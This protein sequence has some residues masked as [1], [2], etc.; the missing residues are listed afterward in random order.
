MVFRPTYKNKNR[1]INMHYRS[2]KA[3][4][5]L[6][7][8][9]TGYC[10]SPASLA[11]I[12]NDEKEL[13][14]IADLT[15]REFLDAFVRAPSLR[16]QKLRESPA[17]VLVF[18]AQDIKKMG[19]N[20]LSDLLWTVAGVQVQIRNNNRY[21]LW[22]RG[23]QTEFN[24]KTTLLID[25][26]PI[27]DFFGGFQLDEA[28]PLDNVKRIEIIRGPGSALY[29]SN[30]FS[31]SIHVYT[32]QPG[33]AK[34][35]HEAKISLGSQQT[36]TAYVR[37]S[38]KV[39]KGMSWQ[40]QAKYFDTQGHVPLYDRAG[41]DNNTG[42]TPQQLSYLQLQAQSADKDLKFSA[43]LNNFDNLRITKGVQRPS[44]REWKDHRFSL[45]YDYDVSKDID[46][47]WHLYYTRSKRFEQETKFNVEADG[48]LGAQTR[49]DR[50]TDDI[51]LWGFQQNTTWA[52]NRQ[53]VVVMG[54]DI[55]RESMRDS[56]FTTHKPGVAVRYRTLVSKP[57][58][59]HISLD[60]YA[61]FSQYSQSF[62]KS[63]T[64]FTA[65]AR[66]DI[67]DEFDDQFSYHLG[68]THQFNGDWSGK[69]L[70]GTAFRAS[71]LLEFTRAADGIVPPVERMKTIEAQI[72]Y[73]VASRSHSVS[74]YHNGYRD[75]LRRIGKESFGSSGGQTMYGVE[76]ENKFRLGRKWRAFFNLGW[77][78]AET[79]ADQQNLP[80][81]AD[82]NASVGITWNTIKKGNKWIASSQWIVY[83]DRHDW[84]DSFWDSG[85][86]QRYDSRHTDLT[87]GF[88][89]W[90]L[91]FAYERTRGDFKGLGLALKIDN[92]LDTTYYTQSSNTPNPTKAVFF[93]DQYE[94]RAYRLELS[95]R[96]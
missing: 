93:D 22:T 55:Q 4:N 21:N 67:L 91:N 73:A 83:G 33:E 9:A 25:D 65:G 2:L 79:D 86:K 20:T 32:R 16:K 57:E 14:Q 31:S 35:K 59:Q 62:N 77:V 29:G 34:S 6:L 61:L 41:N 36:K 38:E 24:N 66:Y 89:I 76:L 94:G 85:V 19:A 87:D 84:T 95:Y 81:L 72:T 15:P 64:V 78:H 88:K 45:R 92:V 5:M 40:L 74:V 54:L 8:L 75:F 63:K 56:S 50:F 43:T 52:L 82:W 30:A 96:W 23:V 37:W 39:K 28:V 58:Y 60:R 44:Y 42:D 68:L 1:N 90:N 53:Q 46:T 7:V 11:A 69:L 48:S 26:V 18:R 27:R 17:N 80:L 13:E 70:Y 10:L 47:K 3:I 71:S 12:D 51:D 49:M